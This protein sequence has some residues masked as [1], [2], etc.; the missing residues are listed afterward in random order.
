MYASKLHPGFEN[1]TQGAS[2]KG[3]HQRKENTTKGKEN[4]P[5]DL[6]SL[7]WGQ[8]TEWWDQGFPW[9]DSVGRI[10]CWT[11]AGLL[12]PKYIKTEGRINNFI[13][14]YIYT[15]VKHL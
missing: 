5:S 7:C 15:A 6:E 1:L 13:S 3:S 14:E 9:C 2:L 4:I 8:F 10:H 12:Q 11:K